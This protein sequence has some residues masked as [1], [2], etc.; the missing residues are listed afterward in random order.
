M[1]STAAS[2]ADAINNGYDVLLNTPEPTTP[3][4]EPVIPPLP[5][6]EEITESFPAAHAAFLEAVTRLTA[7]R[8]GHVVL[9]TT[10]LPANPQPPPPS[11]TVAA[12]G[13]L[14][15]S[16][17]SVLDGGDI[18]GWTIATTALCLMNDEEFKKAIL[19]RN[20]IDAA[21]IPTNPCLISVY[22]SYQK[23][24]VMERI[25]V[26]FPTNPPKIIYVCSTMMMKEPPQHWEQKSNFREF[27]IPPP[28]EYH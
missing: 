24:Y 14:E 11:V 17:V 8:T 21:G 13:R 12:D 26:L 6:M 28:N 10:N 16:V 4:S 23:V 2:V 5:H 9:W 27:N 15:P 25:R 3:V 20:N 19:D 1:P 18:V 22:D 7:A